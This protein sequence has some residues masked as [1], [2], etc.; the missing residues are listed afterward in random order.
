MKLLVVADGHYYI[1]NRGN[2]Y[3]ESVFDYNF[4]KRYLTVFDEVYAIA[5]TERI[6]EKTEKMKIASGQGVHF[7]TIPP[8]RGVKQY[9][10]SFFRTRKL[11]K[12]YLKEF[13]CAI[14]RVPGVVANLAS[15]LYIKTKKP[16]AIEVVVDPWEYFAKGTIDG[17]TRPF[18]RCIWTY[19]LKKICKKAN[20]VSYVTNNYLQKKYPCNSNAFTTSYSSVELADDK[21]AE[22]RKYKKKDKYIISHVA[23]AFTGYGKGHIVL[24]DA[25][26][27]VLDKGYNVDIWFVG[28]GPKRKE[29]EEYAVKLG[30]DMNVTFY[31]RLSSG[32][33]VREVISNSDMFVFPTKAEGLPRVLLEAM[34]E[35]LPAISSP[36][37]GI[38][39]I[40]DDNCMV[41]FND[42]EGYAKS[43][44]QMIDNPAM[45]TEYSEKNIEVSK[46]YKR[47]ILTEKRTDFYN[48]LR[49]FTIK[50]EL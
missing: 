32:E 45:M 28:D 49:N 11:I 41:D 15:S 4:Y 27:I 26:K 34:A 23:N 48:T 29:F 10:L 9:V 17:F 44:M 21:F 24:M 31:G 43:I 18:V 30:I 50:G 42:S 13:E 47:S 5:R 1:D 6:E 38:P 2:V 22:P 40:L 33:L 19:N 39:E 12:K 3:V 35:G 20:G 46:Q 37:C 16:F 7:L 25:L 36:V 14:F 8:T